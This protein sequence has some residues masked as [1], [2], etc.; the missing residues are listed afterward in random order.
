MPQPSPIRILWAA[1]GG[2][3][4]AAFL[5][6]AVAVADDYTISPAGPETVTDFYGIGTNGF[7]QTP[8]ALSTSVDGTRLYDW[9]DV[10]N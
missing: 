10:T 4:G 5:P 8:P 3:L 1:A 6:A 7:Q 2:L 9:T